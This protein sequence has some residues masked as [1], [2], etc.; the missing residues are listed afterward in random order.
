MVGDTEELQ[1]SYTAICPNGTVLAD[2][3]RCSKVKPGETVSCFALS[4][5]SLY[6]NRIFHTAGDL[7]LPV[8]LYRQVV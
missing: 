6:L 5:I 2:L 3:K 4:I 8:F 7:T 1:M